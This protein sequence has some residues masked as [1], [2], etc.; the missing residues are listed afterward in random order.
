MPEI[1][2][3]RAVGPPRW[4]SAGSLGARGRTG[5][6]SAVPMTSESDSRV[7]A[8]RSRWRHSDMLSL[9]L[10]CWTMGP[11]AGISLTRVDGGKPEQQQ[12]STDPDP[13]FPVAVQ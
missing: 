11:V 4:V 8:S 6:E 5:W 7:P 10:D 1:Q 13:D 3:M 9:A 2:R 12:R